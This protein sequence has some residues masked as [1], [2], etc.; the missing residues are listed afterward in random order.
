MMIWLVT[1]ILLVTLVLL[2]TDILK[3][4][5]LLLACG[6]K[7]MLEKIDYPQRGDNLYEMC[8]VVSRKKQV[9]PWVSRLLSE[10]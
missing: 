1:I 2:I 8:G 4:D 6:S 9:F 10:P 5:S 7:E 3:K